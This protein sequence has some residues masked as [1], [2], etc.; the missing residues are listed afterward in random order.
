M[1]I[2]IKPIWLL[3]VRVRLTYSIVLAQTS[4]TLGNYSF[5]LKT[6]LL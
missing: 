6:L 1:L 3:G 4:A 5:L 2:V